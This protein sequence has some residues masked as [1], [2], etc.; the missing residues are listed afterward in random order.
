[1][2]KAAAKKS[3]AVAIAVAQAANAMRE[4]LNQAAVEK[5]E[6]SSEA[7]GAGDTQIMKVARS[8]SSDPRGSSLA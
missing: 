3:D 7:L 1:M 4:A 8:V 2:S 6:D 5:T